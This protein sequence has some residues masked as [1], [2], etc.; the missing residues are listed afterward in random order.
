M[1]VSPD[2]IADLADSLAAVLHADGPHPDHADQLR[3][4][5]RFVGA[6]DVEWLGTDPDG[7]PATMIGE[8]HFGW[9]LGGRAVQDVWRV[10]ACL[11]AP[12]GLRPFY[13]TTLRCYDPAIEAWR[14]T[15]IDPL[16]G[17]VRR[18]IGRPDGDGIILDGLDDEP[19]ERWCFRDITPDSF[20]WTG[21]VSQDRRQTWVLEEQMIIRRRKD[22][23][24]S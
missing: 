5:G 7:R 16:N 11:S 22:G 9:V 23:A 21:E 3:L 24:A 14:S 19:P 8:L 4:F 2:D 6:W 15:W 10:P 20:R 17:R 13:G 18:F 12:A 1:S